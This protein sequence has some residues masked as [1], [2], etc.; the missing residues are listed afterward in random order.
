L[1]LMEQTR[2]EEKGGGLRAEEAAGARHKVQGLSA[3]GYHV[4][5]REGAGRE[6]IER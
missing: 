6:A 4:V 3:E 2:R 5:M 1:H